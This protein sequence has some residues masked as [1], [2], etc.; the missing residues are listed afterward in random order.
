MYKKKKKEKDNSV[1]DTSD[2]DQSDEDNITTENGWD[3]I[4]EILKRPL[5]FGQTIQV[6]EKLDEADDYA[7]LHHAVLANNL[8]A[9]QELI[10]KYHCSNN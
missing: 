7:V 4:D 9:C 3:R 10:G 8:S 2:E 1:E 6:L 5:Y